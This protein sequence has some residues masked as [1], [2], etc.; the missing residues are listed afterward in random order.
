MRQPFLFAVWL[1]A[2]IAAGAAAP[3][4]VSA[5]ESESEDSSVASYYRDVRPILQRRCQGCH[6]SA[7]A[8]GGY[9]L[10]DFE[11]ISSPGD[12]GEAA[13]VPGDPDASYLVDMITPID[14]EAAMPLDQ[15]PLSEEEIAAIRD[16]IAAGAVDDAPADVTQQIDADHPPVYEAAPVVTGLDFAP[17]GDLLAVTGFHEVLLYDASD[18][19]LS[20]RLVGLSERIQSIAFSP[21]GRFLAA[22]GGSPGRLGELQIWDVAERSLTQSLQVGYDTIYGASWSPDGKLVACGCPDNTVR[23][24]D[25]A[26][27]KQVLFQGAHNDWVIDTVFSQDG[28]HL[29]SVSRDMTMKLIETPTERFI[30]NITSITP[31]A[32]RGGLHAVDLRPGQDELVIGGADGVPARFRMFR[33]ED[34]QRRIGDDDNRLLNYAAL[35]GRVYDAIFSPDG[36]LVAAVSS[37]DGLGEARL[38]DADSGEE[39]GRFSTEAGG[40]FAAAFSPSGDRLAVSGFEGQVYILGVPDGE[41]LNS[42]AIGPIAE[43]ATGSVAAAP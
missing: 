28:G 14:G 33:R 22:A 17:D 29:V 5:Q 35:P 25:A 10:T 38:Y 20:G 2:T 39:K 32:L 6:Q 42:F 4:P 13:V 21:D 43:E 27:G 18:W 7:K 23:A 34:K 9:V 3:V 8:G 19:S 37:D 15:S 31:G 36:A 11:S 16:W 12:S 40:L 1:A 24:F 41:A 30:D 26:T